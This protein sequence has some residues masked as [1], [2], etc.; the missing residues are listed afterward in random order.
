MS[1][2]PY[3]T[4]VTRPSRLASALEG[5]IVL[6][7]HARYDEARQAWNLAVDQ[8]PAAVVFPE[9]AQDV[10]TAVLFAREHGQRVAP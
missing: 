8:R 2:Y 3:Q 9:S 5:K 1:T 4:A 10:A 7:A 6:P